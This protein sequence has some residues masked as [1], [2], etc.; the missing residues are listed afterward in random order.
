MRERVVI[1]PRVF[2]A[3][4]KPADVDDRYL[5]WFDDTEKMRF[6][7]GTGRVFN[8]ASALSEIQVGHDSGEFFVYGI[9]T[10]ESELLIGTIKIGPID[11]RNEIADLVVHIGDRENGGKG[12]A[13]EAISLGNTLA[14][15][16][17]GIRK[18][19]GGMYDANIS[20]VRAYLRAGW[21]IEGRLRDHYLVDGQPMD[22]VLV[23][24]FKFPHDA[25]PTS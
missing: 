11:R 17:L 22:R 6:Y 2:L 16:H 9:L 12:I 19:F 25:A 10:N 21:V 4:L 23:A 18:L 13:S 15:D 8:H 7:S 20:A 24:C 3:L 14:F 1:G 5:S